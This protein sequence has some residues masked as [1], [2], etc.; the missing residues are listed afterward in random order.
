MPSLRQHIEE[1]ISS[2]HNSTKDAVEFLTNTN[3]TDMYDY[4]DAS[5]N[6][7]KYSFVAA[8]QILHCVRY[9][10]WEGIETRYS[11][12]KKPAFCGLKNFPR[13]VMIFIV[14]SD[15]VYRI[16]YGPYTDVFLECTRYD[17]KGNY[18]SGK[19]CYEQLAQ[20]IVDIIDR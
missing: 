20:E 6:V 10:R 1:A 9:G 5:G 8:N 18:I 15:Y 13:E 4:I 7:D 3:F 17:F 16:E 11:K 2:R 12:G 19:N 14:T